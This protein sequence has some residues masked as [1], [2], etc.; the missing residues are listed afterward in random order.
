[1]GDKDPK[2]KDRL[3]LLSMEC[4]QGA[5]AE[6]KKLELKLTLVILYAGVAKVP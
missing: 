6:A 3:L 4:R 2:T 1:M 5:G